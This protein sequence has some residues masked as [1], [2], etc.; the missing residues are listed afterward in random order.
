MQE[1]DDPYV[2]LFTFIIVTQHPSAFLSEVAL[3]YFS[4]LM[5]YFRLGKFVF[6]MYSSY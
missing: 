4:Y 5:S 1:K 3:G 6:A 2:N